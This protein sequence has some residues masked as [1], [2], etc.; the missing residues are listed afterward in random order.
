MLKIVSHITLI[1]LFLFSSTG[2]TINMHYCKDSVYDIGIYTEAESCC[3][4]MCQHHKYNEDDK[5]QNHCNDE[6][7]IVEIEDDYTSSSHTYEFSSSNFVNLFIYQHLVV[8]F[9]ANTSSDNRNITYID[10]STHSVLK[11]LSILQTYLL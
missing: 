2:L 5:S 6:T 4:D 3:A 10:T 11:K 8:D 7:F 9:S 1:I